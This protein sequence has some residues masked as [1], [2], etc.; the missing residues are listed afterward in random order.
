MSMAEASACVGIS[1]DALWESID[2]GQLHPTKSRSGA[3]VLGTHEV[4][5]FARN[6]AEAANPDDL[7]PIRS[8][9]GFLGISEEAVRKLVEQGAPGISRDANG[10][11]RLDPFLLRQSQG[12]TPAPLASAPNRLPGIVTDIV[13]SDQ[14]T[15]VEIQCGPSRVVSLMANDAFDE[16][17]L[18]IGSRTVASIQS[19]LVK[20]DHPGESA[21]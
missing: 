19:V 21:R 18:E 9:A 10:V 3:Q 1:H 13:R 16:L 11:I 20:L 15:W 12:E 5:L 7:T 17:G 14:S 4:A 6:R 2:A 8:A